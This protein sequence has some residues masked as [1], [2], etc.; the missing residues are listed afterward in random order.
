MNSCL[1]TCEGDTIDLIADRMQIG[2]SLNVPTEEE[3]RTLPHTE[4]KYDSE[5]NTKTVKLGKVSTDNDIN[6]FHSQQHTFV[7]P[8]METGEYSYSVNVMDE[9]VPHLIN[10]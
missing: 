7:S 10:P 1:E 8:T 9:A 6:E 2:F 5:S 4:V 3:L